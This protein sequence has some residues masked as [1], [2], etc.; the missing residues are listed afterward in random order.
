M[1]N[2]AGQLVFSPSDLNHFLECEHLVQLQLTRDPGM[3]PP[4][5]DAHADLLAAKGLE[6]ETALLH[7]LREEGRHVVD[8]AGP[9][10]GRDWERDA[11]RTLAAMRSGAEVIYQGVLIDDGWR[12]ISDFLVRVDSPCPALGEWSYEAWDTARPRPQPDRALAAL[13]PKDAATLGDTNALL[14]QENTVQRVS[15]TKLA[16]Q[17]K[18]YFVLQLCFYTAQLERLQGRA[19]AHMHVILG[20]GERK[21]F[22]YA[23]FEA[24]YRAVRQRFLERIASGTPV[25]PYP[26]SHCDLCAYAKTCKAVWEADD[27]LS[28]VSGITREQVGKLTDAGIHTVASLGAL[29]ADAQVGIGHVALDRLRHQ[30]SLQSYHRRTGCHRYDLLPIDE[31]SGFRLLPQ[32]STGDIFFDIEG[33]PYFELASGLEYLFGAVTIDTGDALFTA[34]QGLDRE[35]EKCAFE[36]FIDFVH[37]RLCRWPD[38]HVY[39]YGAYE[40][41]ALKRLMS[42]HAT[43]EEE[44]DD[45][46]RREIFVDLHQ[47]VRQSLRI[48]HSSY[49]IKKVRTFFMEGAGRGAV[50]GG[51][52]FDPRVRTLARYGGFVD[53][54]GD[55]RLQPG[56]LR[57]DGEVA[58]LVDRTKAGSRNRIRCR[59]SVEGK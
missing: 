9:P 23:D 38:L 27:H 8:I 12:G 33:D 57:L 39:H 49:S 40:T 43:R 47:V 46:L 42:T 31:R 29:V 1:Q 3:A 35:R 44:L 32:P 18:P 4:A 25:Y 50:A 53:P 6:H 58:R 56:R 11:E 37:V 26:C 28:R 51:R 20:T 22:R 30:A 45:L 41:T 13:C 7:R 15:V 17:S 55:R 14:W 10:G 16:R 54:A 36:Q 24:Y 48:S 5:R 2:V 59:D 19:P 34:F 21:R 52:R